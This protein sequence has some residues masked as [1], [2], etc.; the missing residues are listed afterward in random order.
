MRTVNEEGEVF[1]AFCLYCARAGRIFNDGNRE[2]PRDDYCG[3]DG[4]RKIVYPKD[5]E[6]VVSQERFQ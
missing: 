2:D 1:G 3:F 4:C 5:G 6:N